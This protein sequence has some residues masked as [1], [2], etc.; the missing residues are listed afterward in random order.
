[1]KDLVIILLTA[2]AVFLMWNSRQVGG[3]EEQPM[4]ARIPIE[5][6]V[7]PAITQAIIEQIQQTSKTIWPLETLYIKSTGKDAYDARF[8]FFDTKG[9]FGT[10]YDVKAAV[11]PNGS[12]RIISNTETAVEGDAQNP[13]YVPD[14]YQSYDVIE[15][16]LDRQLR[17]A[18]KAAAAP[19]SK[20]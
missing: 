3:Y 18:L 6:P 10:Q 2:A 4:D 7:H 9:Y 11:D 17:D 16:D 12:V 20:S 5:D 8:M 15:K 14:R 13:A 1:M 19:S